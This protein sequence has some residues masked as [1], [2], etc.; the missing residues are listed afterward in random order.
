[1]LGIYGALKEVIY[2]YLL[3]PIIIQEVEVLVLVHDYTSRIS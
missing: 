1:M 3:F 2:Y